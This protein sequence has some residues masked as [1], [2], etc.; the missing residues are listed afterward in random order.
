MAKN[1]VRLFPLPFV[2]VILVYTPNPLNF[3]RKLI[4]ISTYI[5]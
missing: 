4:S 5:N 3:L 2:F 1:K